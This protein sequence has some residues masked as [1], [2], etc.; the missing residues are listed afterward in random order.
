MS[1]DCAWLCGAI[2]DFSHNI[3]ATKEASPLFPQKKDLFLLP[4]PTPKK[5]STTS[6]D[7]WE[8]PDKIENCNW[9]NF[10]LEC[11]VGQL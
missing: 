9:Q 8:F 4:E 6:S 10:L 7:I 11:P 2:G 3:T 1:E 5:T